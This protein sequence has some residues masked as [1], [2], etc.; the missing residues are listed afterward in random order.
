MSIYDQPFDPNQSPPGCVCGRHRSPAQH[1]YEVSRTMM[2]EA[3]APPHAKKFYEGVIASAVMRKM[4][5][6]A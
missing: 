1:D 6:I 5:R 3:A 4:S 2:C